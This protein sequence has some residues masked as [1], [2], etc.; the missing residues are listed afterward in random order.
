MLL[1]YYR[2]YFR[3]DSR[4][5]LLPKKKA[6]TGQRKITTSSIKAE[7]EYVIYF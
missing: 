6:A 1:R 5:K 4:K 3:S 2:I 7:E